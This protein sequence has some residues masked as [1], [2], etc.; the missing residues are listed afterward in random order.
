MIHAD[1]LI[2]LSDIDGLYTD[3]PNR[4]PN[5]KFIELVEKIDTNL[6][7]MGKDSSGSDF[8]TGAWLPRLRPL[9]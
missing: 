1:L 6:I 8:G 2:L 7:H 3:D 5:A 4:N 9:Q